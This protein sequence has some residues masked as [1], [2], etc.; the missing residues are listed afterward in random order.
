VALTPGRL[1]YDLR[2]LRL[3]LHGPIERLPGSLRYRA[4]AEGLR[5][6]AFLSS[7]SARVL[8]PGQAQLLLTER[9]LQKANQLSRR[10]IADRAG[11][12]ET[13]SAIPAA[14]TLQCWAR[15]RV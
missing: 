13:I 3:H 2:R 5:I 12:A 11:G 10:T 14:E 9:R 6:A 1:T 4:T 15:K 8:T 7:V